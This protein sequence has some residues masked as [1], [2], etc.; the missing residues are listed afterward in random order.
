MIC[1]LRMSENVGKFQTSRHLCQFRFTSTMSVNFYE[2]NEGARSNL[3]CLSSIVIESI[4]TL[5]TKNSKK[6]HTNSTFKQTKN[7]L[8]TLLEL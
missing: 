2:D 3:F 4:R 8:I 7:F 6:T 1:A 5:F